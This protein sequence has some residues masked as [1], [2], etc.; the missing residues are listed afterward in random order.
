M[1]KPMSFEEMS[2][3]G[4]GRSKFWDGFCTGV[5]GVTLAAP[6]LA[7]TVVG[8]ILLGSAEVGCFIRELVLQDS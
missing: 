2:Q 3:V 1:K 5:I 6:W 4:G 8:G 7:L